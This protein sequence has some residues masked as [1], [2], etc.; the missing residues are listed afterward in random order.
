[1]AFEPGPSAASQQAR[2][3]P[4][5]RVVGV[6]LGAER[7][8][9]HV[10][11]RLLDRL[12]EL[13]PPRVGA[14]GVLVTCDGLPGEY[15]SRC[16]ASLT[17]AGWVVSS[18]V[19]PDGEQSK[20]LDQVRAIYEHCLDMG[21]DRG[22]TVFA[23]GGGVVSDLA[24]FAA[25]TY[26]RGI[27]FVPVPT[28]LLSQVDASVGGKTAVD[29]PRA[30][31]VVGAFHQPVAV[32]IDTTTLTTLPDREFRSGMAE[33]VKH[34][35]IADAELF[36]WLEARGSSDLRRDS[37]EI[38][39]VVARNCRIKAEVVV[40]DPR[41][42]GRRAC[43]NFGHTIGHALEVAATGWGLRHGEA[44][45]LGMVAESEM[46]VRL[47]LAEPDVPRRL[48]AVLQAHGLATEIG[49]WNPE[50]ARAA[51]THDKKVVNGRLRLPLVPA[52]GQVTIAEDVAVAE[53][54]DALDGLC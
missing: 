5:A 1:M 32:V 19:V 52:I 54:L 11:A 35:A 9:I 23:L 16:L 37:D 8:D 18:V 28:T 50:V 34:A 53:L 17:A 38:V 45:A 4:E 12:G 21:L 7:Y 20:S 40:S 43:L 30:K 42:T 51:I 27:A 13:V 10:G 3:T 24:G 39:E 25:A 15:A 47:G 29:L 49:Q 36:A 6:E 26:M 41:E 44:V 46:A 33:V 22:S 48:R 31:N 14:K 2:E